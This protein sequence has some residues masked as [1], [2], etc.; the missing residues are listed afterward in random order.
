ME[1]LWSK[2]CL[3]CQGQ[4]SPTHSP[5]DRYSQPI[6]HIP[7][8]AV[9]PVKLEGLA[10]GCG[11]H[12]VSVGPPALQ[13]WRVQL[14]CPC[15]LTHGGMRVPKDPAMVS[16]RCELMAPGH[17]LWGWAHYLFGSRSPWADNVDTQTLTC[18]HSHLF[19]STEKIS[20][21]IKDLTN[22]S[23]IIGHC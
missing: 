20:S 1:K 11:D 7:S 13:S 14:V 17:Y 19:F 18:K 6:H 12:R 4:V 10:W 3:V 22:S 16:S 23:S 21:F 9:L 2:F 8:C 5:K 15:G